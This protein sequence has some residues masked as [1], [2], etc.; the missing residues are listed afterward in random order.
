MKYEELP[1]V[2]QAYVSALRKLTDSDDEDRED[3]LKDRMVDLW[4]EMTPTDKELLARWNS[5]NPTPYRIRA[6][7][8]ACRGFVNCDLDAGI[9]DRMAV[10]V[11]KLAALSSILDANPLVGEAKAIC[12]TLTF[13]RRAGK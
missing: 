2:L 3:S 7:T 11:E 12:K 1:P 4:K 6:C 8:E 5:E 13:Q 9:V 10:L